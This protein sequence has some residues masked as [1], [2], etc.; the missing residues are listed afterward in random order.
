[1]IHDEEPIQE[2]EVIPC[3]VV[4]PELAEIWESFVTE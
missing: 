4:D 3:F 1:M 2:P